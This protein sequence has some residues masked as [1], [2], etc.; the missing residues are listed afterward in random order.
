MDLGKQDSTALVE[1]PEAETAYLCGIGLAPT[2]AVVIG[3]FFVESA[4]SAILLLHLS[5][6]VLPLLYSKKLD[7]NSVRIMQ[8]FEWLRSESQNLPVQLRIGISLLGATVL[9]AGVSYFA[10]SSVPGVSVAELLV[11]AT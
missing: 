5:M 8:S 7:W 9:S 3:L 2:V 4:W 6:L 10:L 11:L 1:V